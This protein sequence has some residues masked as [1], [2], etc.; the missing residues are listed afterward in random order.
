M[1]ENE[2]MNEAQKPQFNIG[3][4]IT[5][6]KTPIQKLIDYMDFNRVCADGENFDG[7]LMSKAIEL[8]NEERE[9]L[10][11]F[12]LKGD[13]NGCGCYDYSTDKDAEDYFNQNFPT[14]YS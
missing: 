1:L 9:L 14:R 6:A 12:Y 11:L 8:L 2:N 7:K 4:V 3:A 10:K 5:S 13:S